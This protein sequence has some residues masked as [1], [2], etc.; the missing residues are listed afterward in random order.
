MISQSRR[1]QT[2]I[3]PL[4]VS[5]CGRNHQHGTL[6]AVSKRSPETHPARHEPA[7]HSAELLERL[8]AVL[9]E[10]PLVGGHHL[11]GRELCVE[12]SLDQGGALLA[13]VERAAY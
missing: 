3:G 13:R 9:G 7:A 11:F 6:I 12:D 4:R 1:R 5:R 8:P 2:K 10:N